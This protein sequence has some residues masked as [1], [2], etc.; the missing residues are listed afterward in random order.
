M[1][2]VNPE[3]PNAWHDKVIRGCSIFP[4]NLPN[5]STRAQFN[6]RANALFLGI[7]F[8]KKYSKNSY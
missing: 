2:R 3:N 4:V 7:R 1:I 5:V 8:S 6:K